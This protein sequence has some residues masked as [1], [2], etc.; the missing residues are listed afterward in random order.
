MK[1]CSQ[2]LFE[3]YDEAKYCS[4]CGRLLEEDVF[5]TEEQVKLDQ[6]NHQEEQEK[7]DSQFEEDEKIVSR[8]DRYHQEEESEISPISKLKINPQ[9]LI[10]I[11]LMILSFVI[12]I[13][14]Y[15]LNHSQSAVS[16]KF[17]TA[18]EK[19]EYDQAATIVTSPISTTAWTEDDIIAS[20]EHYKEVGIDLLALLEEG[21]LEQ[22]VV[23]QDHLILKNQVQ[24]RYFLFFPKYKIQF[25]PLSINFS[26]SNNYRD[27]KLIAQGQ[28][29][30][31]VAVDGG[32]FI[33]PRM[34]E[35]I[36]QFKNKGSSE[37]VLMDLD[38]SKVENFRHQLALTPV[39]NEL[40]V[41]K[42]K[43]GFRSSLP[44]ELVA[45]QIDGQ[46][47]QQDNI[48]LS[49]YLGQ[50]FEISIK[51]KY[52]GVLIE[53]SPIEVKLIEGDKLE[54]DFSHDVALQEQIKQAELN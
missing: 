52:N 4:E 40:S 20:I 25:I 43:S 8:M 34:D 11:L 38:Y 9:Q 39:N 12:L 23:Y 31:S 15:Y 5:E 44:F 24:G 30:Q 48:E 35:I 28:K 16:Q 49:G 1:Q 54:L 47:Y 18:I 17:L 50:S 41:N 21:D 51:T 36:L 45:Y 10:G 29:E 37:E 13:G 3:N 32:I 7:L 26:L 19:Q 2:C 6:D 27:L 14:N 42:L 46:D 33:E 53:S 22:G